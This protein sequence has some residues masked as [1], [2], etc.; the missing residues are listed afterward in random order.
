MIH[1]FVSLLEIPKGIYSIFRNGDKSIC[2][3]VA[4]YNNY[5]SLTE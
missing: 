5:N 1:E 4:E 2:V 3:E